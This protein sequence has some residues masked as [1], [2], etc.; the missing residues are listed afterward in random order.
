MSDRLVEQFLEHLEVE[1]NVSPRTLINYR[2]ALATFRER[3][4][5]PPWK[6]LRADHFRR[7]LFDRMKAGI[8]KPT[9]RLH[10]AA[11]RTFFRFLVERHGLADNPLKQVQLPKL[12][13]KLPVVL[14]PKQIDALLTAPLKME[15]SDKAPKWMP[16][17]DAA[18]LELFYSSGLRLS[19]LAS[20]EVRAI[21]PYNETVRV[22][23]KGRKERIVPV[24]SLA[25]EAIQQYRHAAVVN[26]GP[27]FINKGRKRLSVRSVWL[28]LKRYL[29]HAGIP[30]NISPH[31]L[32]HSFATHMLDAGADLRSVQSLLGHASLSTTQI[33]THVTVERL[34]RAYDDAH[35]RA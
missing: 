16:K 7:Y 8:A 19:E 4:A 9:I 29:D 14:N 31:K 28:S 11:M 33:Y 3:V 18:I 17:R 12:D 32:R 20:L 21:D 22:I 6:E 24:G 15:K 30:S 25:L 2:H 10:F 34:K 5:E 1:R 23:G 27:L 26:A 35:P 13:K